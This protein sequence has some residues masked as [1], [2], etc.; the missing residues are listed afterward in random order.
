ML[1]LPGSK[2][3]GRTLFGDINYVLQTFKLLRQTSQRLATP[4]YRATFTY[5]A[6]NYHYAS[7]R[8]WDAEVGFRVR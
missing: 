6:L 5:Q 7:N 8:Y 4:L 1:L 3:S 2:F